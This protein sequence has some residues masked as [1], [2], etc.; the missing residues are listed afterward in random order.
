MTAKQQDIM[1]PKRKTE[2][3]WSNMDTTCGQL[4]SQRVAAQV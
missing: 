2:M 1:A 3:Y 4:E